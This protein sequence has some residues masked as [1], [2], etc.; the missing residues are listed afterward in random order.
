MVEYSCYV[1]VSVL[2]NC[3]PVQRSCLAGPHLNYSKALLKSEAGVQP[4]ELRPS[5]VAAQ[6]RS[7]CKW[8]VHWL[9][10]P[11]NDNNTCNHCLQH[12]QSIQT[13]GEHTHIS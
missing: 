2:L 8:T 11:A 5:G 4:G 7:C 13:A 3:V 10:D 1:G 6:N 12:V 9:C